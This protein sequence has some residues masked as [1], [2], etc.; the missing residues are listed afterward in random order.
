V[1]SEISIVGINN[2]SN[3]KYRKR[4]SII[5]SHRLSKNVSNSYNVIDPVRMGLVPTAFDL[6]GLGGIEHDGT[7]GCPE[8]K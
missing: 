2:R 6:R 8:G 4:L 3:L 7:G 5:I 1:S